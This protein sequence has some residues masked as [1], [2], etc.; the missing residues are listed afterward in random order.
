MPE[1]GQIILTFSE[2]MAQFIASEDIDS[3]LGEFEINRNGSDAAAWT[4]L[5]GLV[6]SV[7]AEGNTIV[8]TMNET[9]GWGY[10]DVHVRVK[11][12][13]DA[14]PDT[15]FGDIVGNNIAYIDTEFR[16]QNIMTYYAPTIIEP[17]AGE[18]QR[19][20]NLAVKMFFRSACSDNAFAI[21]A[22]TF[23]VKHNG[24]QMGEE[25]VI[26]ITVENE[27]DLI[28]GTYVFKAREW[29]FDHGLSVEDYTL[30]LN[31][32]WTDPDT[33]VATDVEYAV[34]FSA[35]ANVINEYVDI[36]DHAVITPINGMVIRNIGEGVAS[37]Y[38]DITA[39]INAEGQLTLIWNGNTVVIDMENAALYTLGSGDNAITVYA[40][41]A[42]IT[43]EDY[44]AL[45]NEPYQLTSKIL[46][47]KDRVINAFSETAPAP[48]GEAEYYLNA[49]AAMDIACGNIDSAKMATI[50][51]RVE[52]A[53]EAFTLDD[54]RE[55]TADENSG[56]Q[57]WFDAKNMDSVS[58]VKVGNNRFSPFEDVRLNLTG[59][60]AVEGDEEN[61]WTVTFELDPEQDLKDFYLDKTFDLFIVVSAKTSGNGHQFKVIVPEDAI[62]M[63]GT[64]TAPYID[65]IETQVVTID[66]QFPQLV[67]SVIEDTDKDGYLEKIT[68]TFDEPLRPML[69]DLAI[70]QIAD[71]ATGT[72]VT[73]EAVDQSDDFKTVT[74][75]LNG[76]DLDTTTGKVSLIL[77]YTASENSVLVDWAGNVVDFR[78]DDGYATTDDAAAP[79]VLNS[80]INT[81]ED[82]AISGALFFHD[83]NGNDAWDEGEDIWTGA[84]AFDGAILSR[85]W[86]GGDGAWTTV[87]GFVGKA[88]PE[89]VE[90]AKNFRAEEIA[91]LDTDNNGHIDAIDV[92]FSE[93]IDPATLENAAW[94]LAG[95]GALT[96]TADAEDA[97]H[98]RFTFAEGEAYDTAAT[99]ALT[100]DSAI[101]DLAGNAVVAAQGLALSDNAA[102]VLV[103]AKAEGGKIA[104]DT[105]PEGV[106]V[107]LTFSEP[108]KQ[109]LF[110]AE[111]SNVDDILS[112]F[113]IRRN[114]GEWEAITS[115]LVSAVA[116]EDGKIVLTMVGGTTGW[117]M[118]ASID[119]RLAEVAATDDTVFGDEVGNSIAANTVALYPYDD[120]NTAFIHT[121][122]EFQDAAILNPNATN[123]YLRTNALSAQMLLN[124][125]CVGNAFQIKSWTFTVEHDGE[126]TATAEYDVTAENQAALTS[127]DGMAV[128]ADE[129]WQVEGGAAP[130]SYTLKVSFT[131]IDPDDDNA[132]TN[133]HDVEYATTFTALANKGVEPLT[134]RDGMTFGENIAEVQ[135]NAS[136]VW[137]NWTWGETNITNNNLLIASYK[138][139]YIDEEGA[140]VSATTETAEAGDGEYVAKMRLNDYLEV[141]KTYV[142]VVEA[143]D[144]D[145]DMIGK[146]VS[147]GVAVIEAFD[148]VENMV[149]TDGTDLKVDNTDENYNVA[150]RTDSHDTLYAKWTQVSDELT[151]KENMRYKYRVVSQFGSSQ[152][153]VDAGAM[154]HPRQYFGSAVLGD[155]LYAIGGY[156][157]GVLNSVEVYDL[158]T[159]TWK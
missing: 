115:E 85:V 10:R 43:L 137:S 4:S 93:A 31:F 57:L 139:Y 107:T 32:T 94:T 63:S 155:K 123:N 22:W 12:G 19:T 56:L 130:T 99:P 151:A 129:T 24:E 80:S 82:A 49:V 30:Y 44:V 103:Y 86:N 1:D 2:P 60:P 78:V 33:G 66:G 106:T 89:D 140:A 77:D 26:P 117:G 58:G 118:G 29:M 146:G 110:T 20:D 156:Q 15:V 72:A 16:V 149:F 128:F 83:R 70:W 28:D 46:I 142:A 9:T 73:V 90:V 136:N 62:K 69:S 11:P 21:D 87:A 109:Y 135:K 120:A 38:Y 45:T 3:L 148:D 95:Y 131:W 145:G 157:D 76:A 96:A 158:N 35:Q 75:T 133:A 50:T 102:P 65:S 48:Y 13:I 104:D 147:D 122:I 5:D 121:L 84:A 41:P 47:N 126:V 27:Q 74:L 6:K 37:G 14:L 98:V 68:L 7:A 79:V 114:N 42:K 55:L 153:S 36:T 141:G 100:I 17:V 108:V 101:T 116:V 18:F 113:Q 132:D 111:D 105:M 25:K 125:A 23:T 51:V 71:A 119:I 54:L 138:A 8:L 144:A 67:A 34:D 97:A 91:V 39:A 154:N 150:A 124:S 40:D 112:N 127:E 134:V 143:Y 159:R 53:D 61:G 64:D 52:R 81:T 88:L 59:A 152:W 92:I